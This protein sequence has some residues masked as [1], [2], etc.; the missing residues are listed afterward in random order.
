MKDSID[1]EYSK[2]EEMFAQKEP[3]SP[4][5]SAPLSPEEDKAAKR[6]SHSQEVQTR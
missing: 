5:N 6:H 3:V 4:K 1:V 2:L